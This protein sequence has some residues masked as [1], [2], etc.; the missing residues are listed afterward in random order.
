MTSEVAHATKTVAYRK[1]ATKWAMRAT[2]FT[3]SLFGP[4]HG[5]ANIPVD[6]LSLGWYWTL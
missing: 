1:A 3:L 5:D 4:T 6:E 2:P